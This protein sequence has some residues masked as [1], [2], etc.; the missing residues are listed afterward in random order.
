M[1]VGYSGAP[2]DPR[3]FAKIFIVGVLL[4]LQ[5]TATNTSAG[6]LEST[7]RKGPVEATVR[8]EPPNPR[9]GDP[10]TL[11]IRIVAEKGVEL[12]MPGFG[13]TMER[14]AVL[15]YGVAEK[16]DDQ[17]RTVA[18]QTYQLQPPRSGKQRIPPIMIEFV[19]RRDGVEPAPEGLDA[20]ELL[21]GHLAFEVQSVVPDD[22][23]ADLH[24]PVGELPVLGP[25]QRPMWLWMIALLSVIVTTSV[26]WRFWLTAGRRSR[27]RS[28]YDLAAARLQRLLK[29][30]PLQ[31]DQV[32]VFFVE[33]SAIVRWY[34]ENRFELRA[35]EL[36][37]E[38]FLDL[39][40]QSPDL[41][42]DHQPLLREF[43]RRADLVKFA[44]FVPA[45]QDIDQSVAT[46]RQF[47]DETQQEAPLVAR[48]PTRALAAKLVSSK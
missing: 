36:T 22:V 31:P 38:E 5:W 40:S 30:P 37:T 10:V 24:P 34:L 2:S 35:P 42:R 12:L 8:L 6:P 39:M 45:A 17:G 19:D 32:D 13:Q 3:R 23:D 33:L 1:I 4:L 7:T 47:L 16:I 46:A 43:L 11:T 18:T 41:S 9:I 26:A 14:F 15:D 21:T 48:P 20:Y 44:N 28:A 29:R 27:Q 25:S